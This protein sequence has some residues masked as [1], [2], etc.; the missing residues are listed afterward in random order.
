MIDLN[1]KAKEIHEQN[2]A[3]G[4]WDDPNRCI[5][6]TIQLISTEIAEAAEGEAFAVEGR[7]GIFHHF[8]QTRIGHDFFIGRIPRLSRGTYCHANITGSF[9][10]VPA[11]SLNDLTPSLFISSPPALAILRCAVLQINLQAQPRDTLVILHRIRPHRQNKS[12]NIFSHVN[13]CWGCKD[14]TRSSV[15]SHAIG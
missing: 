7:I 9:A 12:V 6:T 1:K 2:K 10:S 5:W 4:W 13:P 15:F 8:G 11:S 14:W 3:V